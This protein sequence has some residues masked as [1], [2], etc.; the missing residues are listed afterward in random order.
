MIHLVTDSTS[1]L[2]RSDAQKLGVTVV[3]LTVR[4]GE[5]QYQDGVDLDSDAFYAKLPDATVHPTT[6]QPT[7]EQFADVYRSLLTNPDD[8]VISMHISGKLSGTLQS[9][10]IAAQDVGADRVRLVDTETVS[11][12]L[13][14]LVRAAL[15]DIADGADAATTAQRSERRRDKVT[16]YVLLDTL[17][18]LQ[19][20]GRI[21]RAQ[22]MVGSMLGV[23]PVL[24]TVDGEVAPAARVRSRKQ[25]LEKI[26][27]LLQAKL[28]LRELA[29]FHC[30]A[31][32]L[33]PELETLLHRAIPDVHIQLGQVGPVVGAYTGPGGVG[34]ACLAV[35]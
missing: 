34:I 11:A 4:F 26:V 18:Y 10:H 9:A 31:P 22:A 3:P 32:A 20:G 28:P 21:G 12:G 7:P 6:S 25:G 29:A 14:L 24:T 5:E 27:E 13:Q 19:R 23:K 1:D 30:G 8:T 2:L 33:L 35:D 15:D 17:T 16:I